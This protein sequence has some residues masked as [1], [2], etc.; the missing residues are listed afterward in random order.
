MRGRP[1]PPGPGRTRRAGPGIAGRGC[2]AAGAVESAWTTPR[3]AVANTHTTTCASPSRR[4]G[5][6]QAPGPAP[7]GEG[8]KVPP[9]R[10]RAGRGGKCPRAARGKS[11]RGLRRATAPAGPTC[12]GSDAES[13][14]GGRR[15]CRSAG[16]VDRTQT[17]CCEYTYQHVCVAFAR[18][19]LGFRRGK[20][21]APARRGQTRPRAARGKARAEAPPRGEGGE[22]P[23]RGEGKSLRGLRRATA[24]RH[25]PGLTR[26]GGRPGRAGEFR[27][28][29]LN[30]SGPKPW[31]PQ[32]H[33]NYREVSEPCDDGLSFKVILFWARRRGAPGETAERLLNVA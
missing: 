3:P 16:A 33:Y 14:A 4:E 30:C 12:A 22:M 28:A 20:A 21:S 29:D 26:C 23:P 19:G 13:L 25:P 10:A 11:F 8:G 9:R 24:P 1:G 15:G 32:S 27:R 7:G 5:E 31:R 6:V 18:G 2:C 17:G